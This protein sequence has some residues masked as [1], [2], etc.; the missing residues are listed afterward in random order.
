MLTVTTNIKIVTDDTEDPTRV[1]PPRLMTVS[2]IE[3]I[4]RS[5]SHI[6]TPSML[7]KINSQSDETS[8]ELHHDILRAEIQSG[9]SEKYHT[10]ITTS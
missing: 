9:S 3:F 4:E 10:K 1:V 7:S 2:S 5:T 8:S 6:N